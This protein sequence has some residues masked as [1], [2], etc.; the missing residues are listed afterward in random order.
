MRDYKNLPWQNQQPVERNP[1]PYR[2]MRDYRDQWMSAPFYNVPPTYAL[3]ASPSYASTPQSQPP[4]STS[5]MEQAI[6]NLTKLV[7]DLLE[8]QKTIN[9]QLRQKIDTMENIVDKRIDGLQREMEYK[10]DNLHKSISSL[11]D[12]HVHQEEE[13]L[14][15]TMVEEQC[16]QQLQKGLVENFESSD[17][18]GAVCPWEKKEAISPLTEEVVEEHQEYNLPLPPI[19]S[20]YILPSPVPQSQP[21]TPTT[22]ATPSALPVLHN[23]IKLV[24]TVRAFATTSKTLV[25]ADVAWHS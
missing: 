2:S 14:S 3:P 10:F 5:P 19:D 24:A 1:N 6:L 4:Q 25:A 11:V 23:I 15:D 12:Q 18:G 13:C 8:E 20:V 7:G 9:A 17:I 22:K 21:K 16:L